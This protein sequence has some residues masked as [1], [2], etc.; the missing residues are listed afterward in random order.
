MLSFHGT[1]PHPRPTAHSKDTSVGGRAGVG[2]GAAPP[3]RNA[4]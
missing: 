1:S 4:L 3:E 2:A